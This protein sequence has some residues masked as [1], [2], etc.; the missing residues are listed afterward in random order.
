MH[1]YTSHR[2][3]GSP[4]RIAQEKR[5]H[6]HTTAQCTLAKRA[7]GVFTTGLALVQTASDG[8]VGSLLLNKLSSDPPLRT[9][10][11]LYSK[12]R[13]DTVTRKL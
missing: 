11:N 3:A 9:G 5:G 13:T 12:Y 4:D 10:V 1:S 2:C 8:M 7:T 6:G